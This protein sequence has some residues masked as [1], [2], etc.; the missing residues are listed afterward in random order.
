[1]CVVRLSVRLRAVAVVTLMHPFAAV[2]VLRNSQVRAQ[3]NETANKKENKE[4][5]KQSL[6]ENK[7]RD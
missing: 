7:E 3:R 4:R 2:R 5:N 1:M 6:H